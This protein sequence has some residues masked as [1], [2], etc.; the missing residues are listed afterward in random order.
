MPHAKLSS[1]RSS[2]SVSCTSSRLIH[3]YAVSELQKD[4]E[5]ELQLLPESERD[6]RQTQFGIFVVHNKLIPKLWELPPNISWVHFLTQTVVPTMF[7]DFP[8]DTLLLLR[9]GTCGK[10]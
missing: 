4:V 9:W 1:T 8:S 7:T 2:F 6:F 3:R 10:I 5:S